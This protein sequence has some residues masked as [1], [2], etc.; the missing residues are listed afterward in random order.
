MP[1]VFS[2]VEERLIH[3][4]ITCAW[5]KN[6]N[7]DA[8]AVVDDLVASDAFMIGL[9]EMSVPNKK[10]LYVFK[11]EEACKKIAEKKEKLFLLAKSPVTFSRLIRDGLHIDRLN[12]GSVHFKPGKKEIYKT[13]YL[14]A[15]EIQALKEILG[16]GI[17]CDI[18]KLPTEPKKDVAE[19]LFR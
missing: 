8:F 2:R 13:V 11:E 17:P 1:V 14:S 4:Q 12:I 18:Q 3:G 19:L 15:E 6:I 9:L 7:F 16:E 10:K 5:A